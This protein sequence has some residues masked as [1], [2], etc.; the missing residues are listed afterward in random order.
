MSTKEV[1]VQVPLMEVRGRCGGRRKRWS[2]ACQG[3][4]GWRVI[5]VGPLVVLKP[6]GWLRLMRQW[7]SMAWW[8]GFGIHGSFAV[9]LM[10]FGC[11]EAKEC[12]RWWRRNEDW[13]HLLSW[14]SGTK[15]CN[16]RLRS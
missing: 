1:G 6:R 4:S 9:A 7:W 10:D 3:G 15:G 12:L 11:V 2:D 13:R 5:Q 14:S 16:L 8:Q